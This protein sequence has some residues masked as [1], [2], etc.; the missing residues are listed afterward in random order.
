MHAPQLD[1]KLLIGGEFI[2][3]Q[4]TGWIDVHNPVSGSG[5]W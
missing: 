2:S 1:A 4:T 5:W 3:S